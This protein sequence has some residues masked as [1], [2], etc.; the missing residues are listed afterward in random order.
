MRGLR[1]R[2]RLWRY[3]RWENRVVVLYYRDQ[4]ATPVKSPSPLAARFIRARFPQQTSP[5]V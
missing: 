5:P 3:R 1:R 4:L 2:W